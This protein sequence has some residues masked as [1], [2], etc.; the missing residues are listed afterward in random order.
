[1]KCERDLSEE[2][3][4]IIIKVGDACE[5]LIK[6]VFMRIVHVL[7]FVFLAIWLVLTGL[8]GLAGISFSPVL[9]VIMNVLALVAGIF[10][11]LS[12]GKC[13]GECDHCHKDVDKKF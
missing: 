9:A 1:M 8:V 5:Y 4:R 3:F 12:V 7:A 13:C 11:L 10:F 6:E 2:T